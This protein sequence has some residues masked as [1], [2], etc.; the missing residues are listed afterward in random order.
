MTLTEKVISIKLMM[1][2]LQFS[3][4]T[5]KSK[6]SIQKNAYGI[7]QSLLQSCCG[8]FV[9]FFSNYNVNLTGI[10]DSKKFFN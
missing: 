8:I 6:N 4:T 3:L 9:L 1:A 2:I 7:I 5:K 10:T